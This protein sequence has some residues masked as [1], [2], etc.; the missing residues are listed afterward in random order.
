MKKITNIIACAALSAIMSLGVGFAI[1]SSTSKEFTPTFATYTNGDG[2][3]YYSGISDSLTGDSLLSALHSLN[4]SKRK[5]TVGYSAMGT[6]PSGQFKYTDYDTSTI[7]YDSNGQPY[8]TQIISFYSGNSTSSFNREHVWP[9]SH[10]GNAVEADIHMPRPTIASENGSRGN[11]FY[12]E[13]KCSSTAGWDPAMESFGKESYRG[14][15]ARIIFYCMI[16]NTNFSLLE[17]DSHTT[18]NSNKDNMEY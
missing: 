17:A 2:A 18:S 16:A 9:N 15:S 3:T 14:D 11:S 12:V 4:S 6:S 5:A 10:G 8:G 1:A 13:G 7:Q